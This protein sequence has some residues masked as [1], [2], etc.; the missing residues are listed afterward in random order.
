[1]VEFAYNNTKNASIGY[2]FFKLN[3]KYYPYISYKKDLDLY[4]KSKTIKKLSFKL[5]NL[6]A[7]Y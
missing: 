7:I 2:T 5:Q 3:Y 4:L 1:M 6:M